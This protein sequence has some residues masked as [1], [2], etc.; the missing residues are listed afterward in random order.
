MY[1][2]LW[3]QPFWKSFSW[4]LILC[5]YLH[6]TCTDGCL[7]NLHFKALFIGSS[8]PQRQ[9]NVVLSLGCMHP[10]SILCWGTHSSRVLLL[11]IGSSPSCQWVIHLFPLPGGLY[12]PGRNHVADIKLG[13]LMA[14][15]SAVWAGV[16]CATSDQKLWSHCVV[17]RLSYI[18]PSAKEMDRTLRGANSLAWILEKRHL[19]QPQLAHSCAFMWMRNSFCTCKPLRFLLLLWYNPVKGA[20]HVI[21]SSSQCIYVILVR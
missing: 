17:P 4:V 19:V 7:L 3:K 16:M 13:Y 14:L 20:W 2:S 15:A 6:I 10:P 21:L 11:Y 9:V 12:S 5:L 18:C 8:P 1:F